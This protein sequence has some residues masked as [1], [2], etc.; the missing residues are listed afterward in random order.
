MQGK[1]VLKMELCYEGKQINEQ[2]NK[3]KWNCA[4]KENK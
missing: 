3:I 4:M 1:N 2:A